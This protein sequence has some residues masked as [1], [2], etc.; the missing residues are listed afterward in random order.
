MEKKKK[1]NKVSK[2]YPSVRNYRMGYRKKISTKKHKQRE[3]REGK[4][5][6]GCQFALLGPSGER[7]KKKKNVGG[8][9]ER[10]GTLIDLMIGGRSKERKA[11]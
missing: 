7:G 11:R 6:K 3:G 2:I 4:V 5:C 9:K 1:K 10:R 8:L